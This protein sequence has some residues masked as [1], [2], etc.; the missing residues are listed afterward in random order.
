[1]IRKILAVLLCVMILLPGLCLAEEPQRWLY[2]FTPGTILSGEG[3]ENVEEVLNAL[4]LELTNEKKDSETLARVVLLSYGEEAFSLRAQDSREGTYA[5]CCSLTGDT[6]LMCRKDQLD[7]FLMTI[8]QVLADLGIL[9]G[10]SLEKVNAVIRRIGDMLEEITAPEDADAPDTGIDLEPYLEKIEGLASTSEVRQLD[11]TDPDCPGAV[12]VTIYYLTEE[13]LT[14]LVNTALSKVMSIPV[15]SDEMKSGHLKIGEQVVTDDFIRELFAST[16]GESV[17]ALY[18]G[19]DG[20]LVKLALQCPDISDLVEDPEFSKVRGVELTIDRE[21]LA[22]NRSVSITSLK[23]IGLAG[24]LLSIRLDKGPGEEIEPIPMKKVHQVG[25]MDSGSLW[26][27]LHSLGLTI[28]RNTANMIL[29]LPRCI[30]DMLVD[31][32]F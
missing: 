30:F 15:I 16:H 12:K 17:L 25:T 1:M 26:E 3:M 6:T 32:L 2:S 24:D 9:K 13:D 10:E 31:K 8:V 19:A 4:Q 5:L 11:G 21:Q 18:E 14:V 7:D 29:V 20:K 28:I 22:E 27:L 23:L